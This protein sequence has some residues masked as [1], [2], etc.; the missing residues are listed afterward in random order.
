MRKKKKLL[1][2]KLAAKSKKKRSRD[3]YEDDDEDNFTTRIQGWQ[4]LVERAPEQ[5]MG[6]RD[7]EGNNALMSFLRY[8]E[9]IPH[10]WYRS[11]PQ[12]QDVISLIRTL[13]CEA[14]IDVA[15]PNDAGRTAESVAQELGG[16]KIAGADTIL[17]AI[18][19]YRR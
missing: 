4:N 3:D 6:F 9:G 16:D 11:E 19:S 15:Q 12:V 2:A 1:A 17:A 7:D 8:L 5:L 14:H 13:V 10:A 18:R